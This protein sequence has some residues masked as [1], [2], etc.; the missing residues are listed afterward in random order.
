MGI[1]GFGDMN[2]PVQHGGATE[3]DIS[4]EFG[5]G[6]GKRRRHLGWRI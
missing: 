6:G 3:R 1:S 2:N 5:M 4:A